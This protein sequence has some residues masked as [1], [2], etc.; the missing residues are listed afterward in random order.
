MS[1][2]TATSISIPPAKCPGQP[3]RG[4][5][6]FA[7]VDGQPRS[8]LKEDWNDFGPRLGFALDVFGNGKTIFRGGYGIFYP[9]IFFRT[10]LGDTQLF[11]TTRT[12]YVAQGPGLRA[13]RF[14]DGFPTKPIESPGASAGPLAL[15]GQSVSINES[16]STTPLTQQWNASL[17]QQIRQLAD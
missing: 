14:Q 5:T 15:L 12:T 7:G 4:K 17:Q 2:T 1:G 11:S 10:F 13:F 8:F 16:D 3:F 9:S 6:V